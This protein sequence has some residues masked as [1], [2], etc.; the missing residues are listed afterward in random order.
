VFH[1][2]HPRF[3]TQPFIIR[4]RDGAANYAS[5][6]LA[7]ALYRSEHFHADGTA[8]VIDFRQGDH[9]QQLFLTVR[10]WF[11]RT[12]RRPPRLEHV[13]FGTVLGDNNKPLKT[14][15][16]D[17]IRLKDLLN[18]ARERA[19]LLVA[20]RGADFTESERRAIA[21]VVGV[22][23]VQYADL[24]QNRSSDYVFSW[25]KMISLEGNTAA[26]LLYAVARIRSIFRKAGLDPSH[27]PVAGATAPETPQEL[28][29]ARKLVQFADGVQLA[30]AQLRPHF[31]C[32]YLFELAGAFSTFYAADKVIVDD[33][34]IRARR[35]LLCHRGLIV[36]E[37]GLHLLGL[38]TLERM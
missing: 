17:N 31:L 23:S 13:D 36:L 20:E 18:E 34:P 15:S 8:Y 22:A 1:P 4:K 5:S 3:A 28:A 21:D 10:K 14:K 11:E 32:L 19:Y 6:D 12:G 38:R 37:T 35:L 9:L 7:T 27:P 2:E 30:T 26:Y 33:P 16:G 29:L 25:D 24:S